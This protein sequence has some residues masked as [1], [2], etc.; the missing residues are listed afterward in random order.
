M[1]EKRKIREISKDLQ[2]RGIDAFL[3][4]PGDDLEY[5]SGLKTGECERF[6]G[7]F[8]LADGSYFCITPHLYLEEFEVAFGSEAPI[9]VWDDKDWFYPVIAKAMNDFNLNDKKLAVNFGVR[10]VD[11]IEIADRQGVK[12]LN[13]WH[14]L[15]RMRIIKSPSEIEKLER[16]TQISDAA[17]RELLGFIRPG[18]TEGDIKRKLIELLE[19]HGADGPSFDIIV[20][21][22]ENASKPHYNGTRGVI[23]ERDLVLVDFGCRYESY[24]SDTTRTIFVG[25]LSDE[26]KNL[27]EVVL[28]AQEAGE[29]AVRPGVMAEEVDRA[30]RSVIEDA[31]YGQYFNTRLGHGIGVA[32]HEAPY[33]M[34]GNKTPLQPGMTFSIEPG[35]YIPGKIGIR[36]ENIVV[37]TDDGCRSLCKLPKDIIVI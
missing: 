31:G 35:I 25:D 6:K 23:K 36:I 18:L 3:L 13:G 12:L 20:A 37:V 1:L 24:C 10:A 22:K 9:Y 5:L 32:I 21:R 33:I 34:E 2:K 30:A 26:E 16:A 29:A 7:L 8:I 15:E 11:A 17:F 19:E 28:N 27:Y 4:G 14:F